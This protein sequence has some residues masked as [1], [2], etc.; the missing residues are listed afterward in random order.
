M[1]D[2]NIL[3]KV[4][5][6]AKIS[7]TVEYKEKPRINAYGDMI[8]GIRTRNAYPKEV[9]RIL[10]SDKSAMAILRALANADMHPMLAGYKDGTYLCYCHTL[11]PEQV[12]SMRAPIL[13][14]AILEAACEYCKSNEVKR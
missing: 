6:W 8:S 12:I 5:E 2:P 3:R 9:V 1:H 14:H 13:N 11:S 10:K 4:A 7:L